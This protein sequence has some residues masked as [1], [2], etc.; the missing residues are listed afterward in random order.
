MDELCTS[1]SIN[2]R[3][4]EVIPWCKSIS[5]QSWI[6]DKSGYATMLNIKFFLNFTTKAAVIH[7]FINI[8]LTFTTEAS[9]TS[10]ILNPNTKYENKTFYKITS[11]AHNTCFVKFYNRLH[12][13]ISCNISPDPAIST[14]IRITFPASSKTWTLA[15]SA[16]TFGTMTTSKPILTSLWTS[17]QRSCKIITLPVY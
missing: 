10:F 12:F 11:E 8:Y 3:N 2:K 5:V 7:V 15:T 1:I 4:G 9:Y 6:L 13:H 16:L 17:D 14:N